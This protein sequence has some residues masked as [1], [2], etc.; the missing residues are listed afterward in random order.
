MAAADEKST[1][2]GETA[3]IE[4]GVAAVEFVGDEKTDDGVAEEFEL[5]VVREWSCDGGDRL[6]LG[7]FMRDGAMGEGKLK[8]GVAG[9]AM[10]EA[11]FKRAA[12]GGGWGARC[13]VDRHCDYFRTFEGEMEE[14]KGLTP[15]API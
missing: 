14:S 3:F 15:I 7:P 8:Q 5:F 6:Q 4:R 10:A 12:R 1:H 2:A 11:G 9:E 13:G